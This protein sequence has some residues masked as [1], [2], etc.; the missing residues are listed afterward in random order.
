MVYVGAMRIL[1][2]IVQLT[3]P[4]RIR[5]ILAY[6]GGFVSIGLS[7]L[8]PLLFGG[9]IDLMVGHDPETKGVFKKDFT[10]VSLF[11]ASMTLVGTAVLRALCAFG[12]TYAVRSLNVLVS[13]D[14]R[15]MLYDKT[16]NMSFEFHD[17]KHTGYLM[18]RSMADAE[19]VCNFVGS[20]LIQMLGIMLRGAIIP[21]ILLTL[22]WQLLLV[23]MI[24]LPAVF[25]RSFVML[26][27]LRRR[28]LIN[29][30]LAGGLS[31]ALKDSLVN[32]RLV[33]AFA[34][35]NYEREK[36]NAR[37]HQMRENRL[38]TDR[39]NGTNRAWTSLYFVLA[40]VLVLWFGGWLVVRGNL[41]PGELATFFL[42]LRQVSGPLQASAG[43]ITNYAQAVASGERLF[44][45]FDQKSPVSD[46]A[47]A[48]PMT[49]VTG[50]VR[51]ENVD[52]SYDGEKTVLN[53]IN[54]DVKSGETI[55]IL[56]PAGSGKTT[57]VDLIPRFYDVD[58]GRITIDGVDI[59]DVTLESLRR[60]VGV[61]RQDVYLFNTTMRENITYGARAA[62]DHEVKRAAKTA[63]IH[64]YI[65]S[66]P[67]GYETMVS[68]WGTTLSGGQ[69]QRMAIAR[70]IITDPPILIMDDSTSNVDVKTEQD[71]R[72]AIAQISR[73]RTTF[74][75]AHRLST[76]L[77][78]DRI[79]IMDQ[80]R[81]VESG[82]H[83]ELFKTSS[84]YQKLHNAQLEVREELTQEILT[85]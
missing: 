43:V 66:L 60:N 61:V 33:K 55:A 11:L 67:N 75:V 9:A 32:I 30:R 41:S 56:G 52:F 64:D 51:F 16:Q 76:V 69:R 39:I 40:S 28:W 37:A 19:A 79:L 10:M 59:R 48:R 80:G 6:A 1:W 57:L 70:T 71:I 50:R 82:R 2:R 46:R 5:F 77:E 83:H 17:N 34:S 63:Q 13:F 74:I 24:F 44:E 65:A 54:I 36:Y 84:R 18:S 72:A 21:I 38:E 68:E 49:E 14:L 15:N 73:G 35:E 47:D 31:A 42:Y 23:G 7:L 29:Q 45:L 8:I 78:A 27:V 12:Q 53:Q 26:Q 58:N 22:N 4:Y 3:F 20:G 25:T 81:I 85:G 62:T